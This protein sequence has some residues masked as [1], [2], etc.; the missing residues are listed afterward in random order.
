MILPPSIIR[1]LISIS[2]G[3]FFCEKQNEDKRNIIK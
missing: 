3:T 2:K 1:G